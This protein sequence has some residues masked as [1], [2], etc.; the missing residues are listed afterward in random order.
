[1]SATDTRSLHPQTTEEIELKFDVL[2]VI[3]LFKPYNLAIRPLEAAR[4][5]QPPS[6]K[7]TSTGERAWTRM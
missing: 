3:I 2:P 1:M 6:G 4:P 5:G 7:E